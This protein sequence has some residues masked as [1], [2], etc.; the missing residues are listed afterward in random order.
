EKYPAEILAKDSLHDL[1][2]LKISGN[3]FP[4]LKL[5]DSDK[6]QIGQTVIAI[7]NALGEFSNTVSRGVVSG[8]SRSIVAS[9]GTGSEKLEQLIQTDAAINPGNSGGPL[10][11]LN[12]EVIGINTAIA[13]G[14]QN[15]GFA[16][17]VNQVRKIINDAS[18]LDGK[19]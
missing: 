18:A 16:I 17:P 2:V 9:S 4:T 15:I 5:G 10:L 8:L 1:A 19:I 11:N 14:A 7:G 6:L 3:K 13:Q 12:G